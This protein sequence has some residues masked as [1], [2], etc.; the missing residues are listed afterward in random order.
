[1]VNNRFYLPG[2]LSQIVLHAAPGYEPLPKPCSLTESDMVEEMEGPTQADS[3]EVDNYDVDSGFLNEQGS[4]DSE[5]SVTD[6]TGTDYTNG[7]AASEVENST[8]P[9]TNLSDVGKLQKDVIASEQ[10]EF[11]EL[12]WKGALESWLDENPRSSQNISGIDN[13]RLS[14]ARIS[15]RGAGARD[16]HKDDHM[17]QSNVCFQ[18]ISERRSE[19]GG[20]RDGK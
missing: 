10:N 11:G 12:M 14:S 7:S 18:G 16:V 1:M 8:D 13:E 3:Y 15:V 9:L 17:G 19:L 2:S 20:A 4:H 6:S 5:E